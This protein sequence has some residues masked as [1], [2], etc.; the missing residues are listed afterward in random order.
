MSTERYEAVDYHTGG[1]PFRI[2]TTL[3]VTVEGADV[4][5]R[6]MFAIGS[7]EVQRIRQILCHEPRGHADMYGGFVVAPDDDGADLG[8]LFWH[9][10]GFSTACGHGTIAL[11][12]WAIESGLVEPDASGTTDVVI[13]VPS[14]RVTARVHTD[15]DGTVT[16]VDFVNVPGYVL[17]RD[18]PVATSRGDVT[19]DVS[20]GGAIYAQL[21]ARSVG[22]AVTPEHVDEIIAIGR[23]IKGALNDSVHAVHPTDDRLSGIY[24]TIVFEDLGGDDVAGPWQRNATIFADGELDR[25]PCGSGTCA[26]LATLT[27]RGA[28][29]EGA[30]LRHESIVGTRFTGTVLDRVD[31]AGRE[32][33]V[34]QVT[35]TAYRTAEHVFVVDPRDDLVPGFVLR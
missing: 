10:D 21:D 35:G 14:G 8:V 4:A 30:A 13:D 17:A 19:V 18:V 12:A 25:S 20:F 3:P 22:L 15:A 1:E 11:G 28:L 9:K 5:S 7:P 16:T 23:E 31:V 6:R 32:A 29:P 33:V 34:P 26:R 27:A 24:G 2:V